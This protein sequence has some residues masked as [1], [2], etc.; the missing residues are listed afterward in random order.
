MC[1]LFLFL[2][3]CQ[4][5]VA[6]LPYSP[7]VTMHTHI[8]ARRVVEFGMNLVLAPVPY[9]FQSEIPA[10]INVVLYIKVHHKTVKDV[11]S[12]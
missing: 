11:V 12:K 1:P 8:V 7:E 2:A 10:D 3:S 6:S 9:P 5:C 4:T